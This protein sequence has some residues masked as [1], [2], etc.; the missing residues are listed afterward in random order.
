MSL[1]ANIQTDVHGNILIQMKGALNFEI[2]S[3]LKK[4]L[5]LLLKNYPASQITIDFYGIEFVGSS[6][7]NIFVDNIN[8]LNITYPQ[9][10]KLINVR[11]EFLKIF[12]MYKL[13][14]SANII[15]TPTQLNADGSNKEEDRDYEDVNKDN[16]PKEENPPENI[17][18]SANADKDTGNSIGVSNISEPILE[19]MLEPIMDKI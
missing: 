14:D 4:E 7:I 8:Q 12:N 9:R 5:L 13:E 16:T 10:I 6:G 2:S 3:P 19:P 11:S 1:L 15:S 17:D 18:T